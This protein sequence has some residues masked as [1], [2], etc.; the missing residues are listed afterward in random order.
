MN[1]SAI[2]DELGVLAAKGV[3]RLLFVTHAW[4]GGVGQHIADLRALLAADARILMLQPVGDGL[5]QLELPG[6]SAL[7]FAD[8]DW[9]P[10]VKALRGLGIDRVHM[11]HVHGLPAQILSLASALGVPL[12]LT[13]HDF[14][15]VCPQYHLADAAGRYCGEPDVAACD[16]CLLRRP[17]AWPF[18]ITAWRQ[19]FDR[20]LL[21]ADRVFAPTESVARGV[22]HYHPHAHISVVPHPETAQQIPETVKVALLGALSPV[23]GLALAVD[24]AEHASRIASPLVVRLIGHAAE[25]LPDSLSATGSYQAGELPRLISAERPDVIWLP[26]QVPETWSYTLSTALASGIPIVATHLGALVER[27]QGRPDAT[28]V[29]FDAPVERWHDALLAAARYAPERPSVPPAESWDSYRAR[30]VDALQGGAPADH[31][32]A[33]R[34]TLLTVGNAVAERP[35]AVAQEKPLI[36]VF[37]VGAYGG[38]RESVKLVETR[39]A[40]IG[41][42]ESEV[43]G[44]MAH[45]ALRD[46]LMDELDIAHRRVAEL[47][48]QAESLRGALDSA[49]ERAELART[50][51]SHLERESREFRESRD[52]MIATASWRLTRPLRGAARVGRRLRS[53]AATTLRLL[54]RSRTL[55]RGGLAR[56]RRGGWRDVLERLRAEYHPRVAPTDIA[57]PSATPGTISPLTLPTARSHPCV[58]I[59]IPVYGQHETTFACLKSIAEN[60]PSQPFEVIVMDDCSRQPAS[61]AL[62]CVGGIRILRNANNLGFIGNVNAAAEAASG[63]WLIVLN[64]DTVVRTGAFDAMLDTFAQHE[65]VGLVGCKLLNADGSVQEAGGIVWRDGSAWNWGRGQD[66]HDPRFNFVRD[67]DYCS[68]AALTIRRELFAELGGFDNHYAPAYYEDTDL[69]FRVRQRGLR[70]LYQPAAEIFHLEGVSH[71]RDESSGVKA[72]QVANA[73][74]FF[75]RWQSTLASHRANGENAAQEAH[76]A[77]RGNILIVEA[78]MVTPDHDAGSVRL[79][80]LLRLLVN[81]GY[82]VSFVADNLD[83]DPK[84]AAMLSRIGVETLHGKFAGSVRRVLRERGPEL[85]IVMFCRHYIASQYVSSCRTLAPKAKVVFDTVDLHFL[86]EERE[87]SLHANAAMKQ[88]AAKTRAIELGVIAQSDVTLVV[89]EFEKKLLADIAPRSCVEVVSTMQPLVPSPAAFGPRRGIVFVGGFRHPPNVDAVTWYACEVL[90][91][92]RGMLPDVTTSIIGSNMTDGVRV[93]AQPGLDIV[94]FVDDTTPWL[95]AARVSIAPLRFGAGVKGKVN[96]AMNHGVPVV[97]TACAIEGMHLV[98]DRDVLVA[99][100]AA[101]FAAAIARVYNDERL[102]NQLS[103]AGRENLRQHFSPEAAAPT[104]LRVFAARDR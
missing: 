24:V 9:D 55:L 49:D 28:L 7:T 11:H 46:R 13:L 1:K 78:C 87:A 43:V 59:L 84:Y 3:P 44:R 98:A 35:V 79:F 26:S 64:N 88:A 95:N 14:L 83:G 25:P 63:E 54:P 102:W 65:R 8:T 100:D 104:V 41:P 82:H 51:I 62:G 27:L 52:A 32:G 39:L 90:P 60:P 96:E 61:E 19:A 58:S 86:R 68:G 12:D 40:A 72:Y 4:G 45:E 31:D 75:E 73:R 20:L 5:Y 47:N 16:A 30:Y 81:A 70:V 10:M 103:A 80:N 67:A 71:G 36:D 66:R 76:R 99:D 6:G 89:S 18:D 42:A 93:L 15:T 17:H 94:G 34:A 74:K 38:H 50:H 23:K 91:I 77:T 48:D 22:R 85:D 97:A 2:H 92:L 57:L 29:P 33:A 37:R 56:F 69:A 53:A 21:S 101:G